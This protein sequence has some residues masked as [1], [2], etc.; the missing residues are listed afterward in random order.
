MMKFKKPSKVTVMLTCFLTLTVCFGADYMGAYGA[1]APPD[2]YGAGESAGPAGA[3]APITPDIEPGGSIDGKSLYLIHTEAGLRSIG[4]GEYGMDQAYML[5]SHSIDLANKEWTPIGTADK[6]FTGYFDGNGCDIKGLTMTDPDASIV[7]LF[8]YAENAVI[9]NVTLKD[10]NIGSAG[11]N[12]P[13]KYVDSICAISKNCNITDTFIN[14]PDSPAP[15]EQ[16]NQMKTTTVDGSVWYMVENETQLRAIGTGVYGLNKNYLQSADIQLSTAE[17][18]PIGSRDA[19]FTGKYD[20][21]GFK[22]T[23]LTMTDPNAKIVGLF[24]AASSSTICNVTLKDYDI[25]SAGK[26]TTGVTRGSVLAW[27]MGGNK[28]YNNKVYPAAH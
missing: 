22:I 16:S 19:P 5:V 1:A 23:G 13:H 3:A 17:W 10:L 25:V 11:V 15:S 8:G 9:H 28:N 2:H 26:N 24:G 14:P 4:T 12:N 27:G 7:G 6:P 21:N 18:I 20:G